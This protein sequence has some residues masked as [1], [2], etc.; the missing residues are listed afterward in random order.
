MKGFRGVELG[1]EIAGGG[2]GGKGGVHLEELQHL[3]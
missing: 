2:V 1:L 3:G